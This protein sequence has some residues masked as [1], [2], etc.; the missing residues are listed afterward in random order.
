MGTFWKV[1]GRYRGKVRWR[2]EGKRGLEWKVTGLSGMGSDSG[3]EAESKGGTE[4][5]SEEV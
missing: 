1:R 3:F 5:G 2:T 4:T